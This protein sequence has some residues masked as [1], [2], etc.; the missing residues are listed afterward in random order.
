MPARIAFVLRAAPVRAPSAG[1]S[2]PT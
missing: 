2:V 1:R